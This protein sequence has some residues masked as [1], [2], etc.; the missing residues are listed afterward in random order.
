[1]VSIITP[2]YNN[3]RYVAQ[4]I[5]SVI[6]QTHTQWEMII[7]D[8]GST[9]GSEN[10]AQQY[11]QQDHRII[12]IQQEHK[13]SAAARNEGIRQA[14]GRYIALLDS[15]DLWEPKFLESQLQLLQKTSGCLVCSAHKRIN[16]D[17]IECLSP[18]FPPEQATH[19]DLLKTCSISCLTALY[20]TKQYGKILLHE[21]F[22]LRDDYILWLEIIKK[23][24]IVYGNQEILAS[25]RITNSQKSARKIK[26]I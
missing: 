13:G 20:D 22:R 7:V 14:K 9:D 3:K 25:Y 12:V 17:G 18:F 8:D 4:T 10:I 24:G 6:A 23:V 19:R 2:L 21:N 26:T 5:E 15:D 11:A 1:M 16:E